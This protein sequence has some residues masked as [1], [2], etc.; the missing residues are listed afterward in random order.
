MAPIAPGRKLAETIHLTAAGL[1][2][3]TLVMTGATAAVMFGTSRELGPML[4][5][6]AAY[7]GSH[8]DLLAGAI[9][10]QVFK[11]SDIIQFAC[12]TL[13]LASMIALIA[14]LKLPVRTISTAVRLCS[15]GLALGIFSYYLMILTPRMQ[16]NLKQYYDAARLG[17]LE[18][19]AE[20]RARFDADHPTASN[21][22]IGTTIAVLLVLGGGAWSATS[23][24]TIRELEPGTRRGGSLEEPKLAR[25]GAR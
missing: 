10:N 6:F 19:A 12:A 5:E 4:P 21:S 9:Q 8:A 25:G 13:C 17:Q 1:W 23:A 24:G 2:L 11:L 20:A 22:L 18:T 15:L 16:T 3:G 14:F 7:D